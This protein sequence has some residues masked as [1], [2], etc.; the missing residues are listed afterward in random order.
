MRRQKFRYRL[1]LLGSHFLKYPNTTT[2]TD[3]MTRQLDP[4]VSHKRTL[5]PGPEEEEEEPAPR[6]KSMADNNLPL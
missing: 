6:S 3:K 2:E 4:K 5:V 1:I